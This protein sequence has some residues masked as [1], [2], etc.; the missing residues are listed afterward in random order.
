[1]EK[2]IT[3]LSGDEKEVSAL[4]ILFSLS[5]LPQLPTIND[6]L[7]HIIYTTAYNIDYQKESPP[8]TNS[9]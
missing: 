9:G 6:I 2:R 5:F 8:V 4:L 3:G 7:P 1:L